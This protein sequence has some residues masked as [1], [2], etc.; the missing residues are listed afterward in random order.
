MTST[1]HRDSL[2]GVQRISTFTRVLNKFGLG[3]DGFAG[4]GPPNAT[5]LE[6][7][8]FDNVQEE[9]SN[10][11]EEQGYPLDGLT[12]NQLSF[13][14]NN[15]AF[16]GSPALLNGAQLFVS[17]GAS[18]FFDSGAALYMAPMSA[19]IV[20]TDN[21]E[22]NGDV[23]IGSDSTDVL[24]VNST[25]S[26]NGP[27]TFGA[28]ATFNSLVEILGAAG[29]SLSADSAAVATWQGTFNITG[30]GRF[31]M[32]AGISSA[33][34]DMSRAGPILYWHDGTAS[35]VVQVS[36]SGG[37]KVQGTSL[38][39]GAA[40][41]VT[42][43]TTTSGAPQVS[44]DVDVVGMCMVQRVAGPGDIILSLNTVGVGQIGTNFTI[45]CPYSAGTQFLP[46]VFMRTRSAADTTA[47][48]YSFTID[49]F[50]SN[51]NV[52]NARVIAE[53]AVK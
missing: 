44:A 29:A 43:T 25:T 5:Q 9:L 27:V 16:S 51:V 6:P 33:A 8:W 45:N 31:R 48:Q 32:N 36:E 30:L 19:L 22:F 39:P 17:S 26:L 1:G 46:I 35:R 28:T 2:R 41:T 42:V 12:L 11:I 49:G 20:D 53:C 47:R 13:A 52:R 24:A 21:V 34:G 50:G 40:A 18:V 37:F 7:A 23:A 10:A 4:G 38:A 14:L 3:K 15:F